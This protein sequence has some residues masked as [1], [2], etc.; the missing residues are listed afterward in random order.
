V[1]RTKSKTLRWQADLAKVPEHTLTWAEIEA[2]TTPAQSFTRA[3]L[4]EWGVPWPPPHGWRA[5]ITKPESVPEPDLSMIPENTVTYA[6]IEAARSPA[7]GFTRATL[8]KWGVPWPPPR[9]W[10]EH[11]TRDDA[12][13]D[14]EYHRIVAA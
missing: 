9:G 7:G 13:L 2:K 12:D 4:A 10:R 1:A 5:K 6:D 8:A 11:I 3:Q 14:D